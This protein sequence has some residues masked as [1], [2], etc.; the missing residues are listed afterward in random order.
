MPKRQKAAKE[1]PPFLIADPRKISCKE[2]GAWM[3]YPFYPMPLAV[4]I[5]DAFEFF[6]KHE[7]CDT[8]PV[9]SPAYTADD[10]RAGVHLRPNPSKAK[11]HAK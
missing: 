1:L 8:K 6:Q 7:H 11:S 3:D 5:T 2:C 10:I 4:F 9:F